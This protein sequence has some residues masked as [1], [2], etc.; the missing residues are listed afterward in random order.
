MRLE[1]VVRKGKVVGKRPAELT[2]QEKVQKAIVR[3]LNLDKA[4]RLKKEHLSLIPTSVEVIQ[5]AKHPL[6]LNDNKNIYGYIKYS[7]QSK[8]RFRIHREYN[9]QP[10]GK[11]GSH[12]FVEYEGSLTFRDS[13][14]PMWKN[15]QDVEITTHDIK[16]IEKKKARI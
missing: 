9:P 1:N 16:K 8:V 2:D 15:I 6:T 5:H 12:R 13:D 4:K 3:W 11:W 7:H 14:D 10:D